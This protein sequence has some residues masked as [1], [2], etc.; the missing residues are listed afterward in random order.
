MD[1]PGLG[2]AW[3]GSRRLSQYSSRRGVRSHVISNAFNCFLYVCID[4]H[5]LSYIFIDFQL[6]STDFVW[7]FLDFLRIMHFNDLEDLLCFLID[8]DL[9]SLTLIDLVTH[10]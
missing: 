1:S 10:H 6:I 9:F 2:G 3:R 5:S 8:F 4:L 7:I